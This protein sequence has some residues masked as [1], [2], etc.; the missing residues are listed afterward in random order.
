MPKETIAPEIIYEQIFN[1]FEAWCKSK[2]FDNENLRGLIWNRD[3]N[4]VEPLSFFTPEEINQI[5][6]PNANNI[7]FSD[8]PNRQKWSDYSKP[9][10]QILAEVF[11][12][13]NINSRDTDR[14][15]NRA[16]TILLQD[17]ALNRFLDWANKSINP[18]I[19]YDWR[20]TVLSR[21]QQN[22]Y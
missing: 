1:G 22:R 5:D 19:T 6:Y 13:L 7:D 14:N 21:L 17:Q 4:R 15:R 12:L 8:I 16:D 2:S 11:S 3:L 9:E 18:D 10:L 20:H